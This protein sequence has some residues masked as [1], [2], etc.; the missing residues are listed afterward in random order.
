MLFLQQKRGPMTAY[1]DVVRLSPLFRGLN[2]EEL[3]RAL[4]CLSPVISEYQRGS[5]L[6]REGDRVSALWMVLSGTL[7]V[8]KEDFWGNRNILTRL[9]PGD[10]F[11]ETYACAG[12]PLQVSVL[13]EENGRALRL[14]V[15]HILSP[16]SPADS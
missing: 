2:Q 16:A 12:T 11:A 10:L 5:F 14:E 15:A 13:A 6:L 1:L 3:S 8:V 7:S 9:E 4:R